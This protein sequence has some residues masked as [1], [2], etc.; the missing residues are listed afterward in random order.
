M[1]FTT[2]SDD[3]YALYMVYEDIIKVKNEEYSGRMVSVCGRPCGY[4]AHCETCR[5]SNLRFD[6]ILENHIHF[7]ELG[8]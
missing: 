6:Y 3:L 7:L 1:Y 2:K 4:E 8:R 5:Y